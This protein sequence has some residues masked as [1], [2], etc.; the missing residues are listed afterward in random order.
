MADNKGRTLNKKIGI[1]GLGALGSA[2]ARALTEGDG[3]H[4]MTLHAVS[5]IKPNPAFNVPNVSFEQLGEQCDLVIECLPPH[6]V[7]LLTKAVLS[8]HKELVL[9]SSSALL[10]HPEIMDHLRDS[11]GRILVPSGALAGIDAVRALA[12]LGIKRAR[13]ATTKKPLGFEG[14]PF[15][16]ENKIDLTKIKTRQQ[17]FSGNAFEAAE[18]FPANINVAVTL[19]LA[20]IGPERT[21]VE[22]WADP[23][24]KGNTHEIIVES[25]YSTVTAR[26]ENKPDPQNP[27]SSVL[28]GQS[29]VALLRGMTE[30]LVVRG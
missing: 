23:N 26:V 25:A 9:I 16:L 4:N 11:Q 2:V 12:Q 13:I 29:I 18:G 28:A 7:P 5:D 17:L 15:I 21:E 8:K 22:I 24:A 20:G 27:K 19:S 1:A 6:V 14:A 3:I 30:P 10:L